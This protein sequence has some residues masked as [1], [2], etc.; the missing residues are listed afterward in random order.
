MVGYLSRASHGD[1]VLT[2]D[3]RSCYEDRLPIRYK[4]QRVVVDLGFV[5]G[6][7]EPIAPSALPKDPGALNTHQEPVV[8]PN[9]SEENVF[10][11]MVARGCS[12][13]HQHGFPSQDPPS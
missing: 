8:E 11:L 3:C 13:R 7:V 12:S 1:R 5:R 4:L 6:E 9:T 2:A 10:S